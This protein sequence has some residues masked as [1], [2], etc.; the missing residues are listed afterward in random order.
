MNKIIDRCYMLQDSD[1]IDQKIHPCI[2]RQGKRIIPQ[3]WLEEGKGTLNLIAKSWL[4]TAHTKIH[5]AM[6]A[7]RAS[8]SSGDSAIE[9]RR[10]HTQRH[11]VQDSLF[12]LAHISMASVPPFSCSSFNFAMQCTAVGR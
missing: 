1:Q 7:A 10:V 12:F 11:T 6:R 9:Q 3:R 4:S 8:L 2:G 5:K